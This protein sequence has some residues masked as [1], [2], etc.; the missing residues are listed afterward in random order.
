[1]TNKEFCKQLGNISDEYIVEASEVFFDDSDKNNG[2]LSIRLKKIVAISACF[3][4]LIASAF[5]VNMIYKNN[6]VIP[7]SM[8]DD[9]IKVRYKNKVHSSSMDLYSLVSTDLSKDITA[10][11]G[12]VKSIKNIEIDFNGIK[13][14][15][16]IA[17]IIVLNN[18]DEDD[19][20]LGKGDEVS[21]L[22]PCPIDSEIL[23][24]DTGVVS[25]MREGMQGIFMP[26]K[27]DEEAKRIENGM[28][29]YLSDLAQYGFLDGEQYAFIETEDKL[30][31]NE[32]AH[33][34]VKDAKTL[35]DLEDYV[36]SLIDN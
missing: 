1:M 34:E 12:T 26:V 7:L 30:V 31:F 32:T 10:F 36:K 23:V 2:S 18:F 11:K 19:S 5:G 4:L 15:R 6:Q 14:Y 3:A 35:S 20:E 16:A 8:T 29:L 21:V 24:E 33:K 27:Y 17:Q 9:N 13:D 22:L 28:V 25:V